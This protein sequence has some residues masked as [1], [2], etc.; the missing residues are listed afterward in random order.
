MTGQTSINNNA[1]VSDA[2]P[3]PY[4]KR[5]NAITASVT[6]DKSYDDQTVVINAAA[7]L[8]CTLPTSD[9]GGAKY[10]FVI[11]TTVTSNTVVIKVNNTT[12]S[13]IGFSN[14]IS[15]DAGGPAKGFIAAANSDDTVTFNGTTTGGY[16][17][18]YVEITDLAAGT[19][20]VRVFGK[21]TGTEATPFSATV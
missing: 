2:G 13:I 5:L 6:M 17:G 21:A 3:G 12:D 8:T 16:I 20:H 18:D 7:G 1:H 19:F 4:V 10:R 9:G 14:I 15:D 11:G